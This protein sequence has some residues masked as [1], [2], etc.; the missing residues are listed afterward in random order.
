[1]MMGE[2]QKSTVDRS[3]TLRSSVGLSSTTAVLATM[4]HKEQAIAPLF[5]R[6]L[7]ITVT[8]APQL[9][10][11]QFGTF[12]RDIP[13]SGSQLDAARRKAQA[14]IDQTGETMAIASEGA[15]FPHPAMPLIPC[16]REIVM[17][18]DVAAELELVGEVV[19]TAT[20]YR[21]AT[22]RSV[23]EALGFAQEVEFPSH[24]LVV[25]PNA[26]A[27]GSALTVKGIGSQTDL[28]HAVE[29]ALRASLTHTAHVETDMRAMHN[30][31]R[32][33]VIAEA[34]QA[35]VNKIQHRCPACQCPGFSVVDRRPG[36]PCGLCRLPTELI[37]LNI[38][39]CQRCGHVEEQWF[40]NGETE[41][42][43]ARCWNCNP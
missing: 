28:I 11:D 32:M 2:Q 37:K 24:R 1:M 14:A 17:L 21:H 18:I 29:S 13:R 4:H 39:Q 38:Q 15:F 36:L 42:D 33:A 9:N 34:A 35:L 19:S 27:G 20:N 40:P 22:I 43:P 30:P 8:V 12:T 10:T 31:T 41:A 7:G 23:D 5:D 26:D 16:N 6:E 3:V 25:M